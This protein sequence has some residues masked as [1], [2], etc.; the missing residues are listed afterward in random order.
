MQVEPGVLSLREEAISSRKGEAVLS[1][2]LKAVG[3]LP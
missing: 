1:C 2:T 3:V